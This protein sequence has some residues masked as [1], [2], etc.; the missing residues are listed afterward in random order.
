MMMKFL[1]RLSLGTAVISL[2][3][4]AGPSVLA[5]EADQDPA[6]ATRR[7]P[8]AA[9]Q[10]TNQQQQAN[11]AQMPASGDTTTQEAKTFSGRIVKEN[12]DFVLKDPVTKVTYKLND[13]TKAKQYVGKQVKVS[14]KLDMDSTTIQVDSI[15]P[16]S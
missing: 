5:Q 14:G 6:P 9:N 8:E 16:I 15:E 1:L 10:P 2:A 3:M 4:A 12:G 11:E 13:T 7:Q